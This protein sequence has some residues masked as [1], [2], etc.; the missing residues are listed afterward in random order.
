MHRAGTRNCSGRIK[1]PVVQNV[2]DLILKT[3]RNQSVL[4]P[5]CY[6]TRPKSNVGCGLQ[7]LQTFDATA[8]RR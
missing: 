6:W 8:T 5:I 3:K 2:G 1:H 7:S 4:R